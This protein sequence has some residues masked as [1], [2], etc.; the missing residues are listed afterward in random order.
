MKKRIALIHAVNA[1]I[2][3]I[4]QAFK[5]DWPEAELCNLLDDDLVPAFRRE[6]G[7]TPA[8][9]Q[10]IC[11]LAVYAARTGA[12]GILFTCSVFTP[13]EELAKQIVSIP[14]LKPDEAMFAA[15]LDTGKRIGVLATNPP[16]A[17]AAET[18]LK[19][20]AA[21]RGVEITVVQAVA[22]GAFAAANAGDTAAHDRLVA[23]AA[24]RLSPAVDVICMAQ[25]SMGLARAA[26][27]ARSRVPILTS[28][29][30][31]V[32]RLKA[33]LNG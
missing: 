6:G 4:L 32:A 1:A 22:E 27:Q 28:P 13:A 17:P 9:T 30:T 18:Q 21:A 23:E 10:R 31:A 24:E 2:P 33:L 26:A 5:E 11:E 29:A 7:L 16:A 19:E 15:A 20:A 14:L 8:I 25:V 12:D 3:P